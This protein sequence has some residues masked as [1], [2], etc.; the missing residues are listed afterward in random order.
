MCFSYILRFSTSFLIADLSDKNVWAYYQISVNGDGV[1]LP[2]VCT[3]LKFG[4]V[5]AGTAGDS[6]S[7]HRGMAFTTKDK[8]SGRNCAVVY[9]GA[10]WYKSCHKSNLNGLYH[11]GQH[12]S[13]ADGVNWK[14]WKGYHYSAKRAEMKIR[15]VG[16]WCVTTR[17][18]IHQTCVRTKMSI[19]MTY[20][21]HKFN[22][23]ILSRPR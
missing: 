3:F 17:G 7:Y 23:R 2:V 6:L 9:K 14:S 22:L 5:F 15:P 21:H 11:H 18:C 10:W 12:S 8:S 16:F 20:T 13:F 4:L 1:L 19:N